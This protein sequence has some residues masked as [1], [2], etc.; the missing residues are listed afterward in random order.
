MA[1]SGSTT[2]NVYSSQVQ[3]KFNW[4]AS[5][6]STA[7]NNTVVS[8][9]LQLV[10]TSGSIVSSASKTWNVSVNGSN[11][12]G[13]VTFGNVSTNTTKTLASGT[14]TV[15]HNADGTK[16]FGYSFSQQF[17]IT[18]NG[19]RIGTV[20]GSGSGT[21]NTIPRASTVSATNGN[22]G[23]A[24]S[25][26]INRAS[27][28]FTHTLRYSFH[29]L[30]A[31][32]ATGVGT[33]YS[34]TIPT[35]FYA[36]IPNDRSSWGTIFVDT[37]NGSTKIGTNSCRFDVYVAN[38]KPTITATV[39][40]TNA[41][42]KALTGDENKLVKYYSTASFTANATAKNSSTIHNI[43]L[44]YNGNP[45]YQEAASWTNQFSNCVDNT[46]RFTATDSRGF[47]TTT[48]V[49]KAMINY[50]KLTCAMGNNT[51]NAQGQ[52]TVTATGN[53]FNG[54]FGKT[55]NT[56][57]VQY[58]YKT[59]GGSYGSWTN[60]TVSLSGNT[61][62]ATKTITGL[63]YQ[64]TYVFQCRATDKLA[65][66]NTN[67][68]SVK[69]T[70]VFDWSRTDFN[71]NVD[72]KFTGNSKY[73]KIGTGGSDVYFH[74][75]KSNKYLQLKDNG[76]LSYS[77]NTIFDSS[78][79]KCTCIAGG[80]W[81]MNGKQTINF[82]QTVSNFAHGIILTFSAYNPSGGNVYEFDYTSFFVPKDLI[83][84]RDGAGGSL[85]TFFMTNPSLTNVG[86]KHICI[87][88]NRMVGDNRNTGSGTGG[89]GIKYNNSEWV[90]RWVYGV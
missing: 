29:D 78:N 4:S 34:W 21:L 58:R 7:N 73:A 81:H 12:S 64:T 45:F 2:T 50:V 54:S 84:S 56:L 83:V 5:S 28:S 42:T 47:Y 69:S 17:D 11:Y 66:V 18:Y 76:V 79:H 40:D 39:K 35:S 88:N 67:E 44:I 62:S 59:Q 26:T 33:S 68:I 32:I 53:Y 22:I 25:I 52:M 70:P 8:W 74:N 9:N 77:D 65:T 10:T 43:N 13:T 71:F 48:T 16:T 49:T 31:N 24:I 80:V 19:T 46:F 60:L 30:N 51:P 41:T 63:N 36:K 27:S 1:T 85:A 82:S 57:T 20:S 37:Y 23:S 38:S 61:Y 15:G 55:A 87:Y 90:L 75:S 89:S 6:Q 14:T 3:L 72:V 86:T